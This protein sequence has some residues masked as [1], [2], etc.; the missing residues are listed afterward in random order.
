[1]TST[2]FRLEVFKLCKKFQKDAN[3]QKIGKIIH[4]MSVVKELEDRSKSDSSSRNDFAYVAKHSNTEFHGF[5]YLDDNI[6]TINIPHFFKVNHLTEEERTLIEQGHKTLSRFIDLCLHD[7]ALKS[8]KVANSMNPYFLYKKVDIS[9]STVSLL[10]D[11]ELASAVSAFKNGKVYKALMDANFT[12]IF[13]R[14]D[15]NA[16]RALI[17]VLER[18]INNSLGEDVSKDLKDFSMKLHQQLDDITDVMFAFSILILALKISLKI[19]CHLLYRAI[20]GVDLFVLNNDN[21][22]NIEKRTSTIVSDFYKILAQDICVDFSG[23]EMGS[24]LLVDCD[25]TRDIHIHEFGMLI[26]LTMN[27]SGEFGSSSKYSFVTVDEQLINIHNLVDSVL[28]VGVP[29]VK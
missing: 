9:D 3:S 14:I 8:N 5:V 21:I 27:I 4:D 18:E 20:C 19:A 2:N 22:I 11:D 23:S 29:S 17:G 7:I 15:T 16:M 1:M 10:S 13:S 28:N 6:E 12:K 26:A 24:V 25:L